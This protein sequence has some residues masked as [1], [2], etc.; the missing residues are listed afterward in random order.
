MLQDAIDAIRQEKY[1]RARDLLTRL[2]RQD[3]DNPT[4]WLWMSAAVQNRREKIYCLQNVIRND[5]QNQ[6]AK[7]GLVLLGASPIPKNAPIKPADHRKWNADL[8]LPPDLITES[9]RKNR[10]L[11]LFG[12]GLGILVFILILLLGFKL[13]ASKS[14]QRFVVAITKTEGVLPSYTPSPTFI[15]YVAQPTVTAGELEKQPTPLWAMLPATYTPTPIY[16]N[17]PHPI[18][19]A[20]RAGMLAYEQ[21]NWTSAANFFAQA[22]Q[23][24]TNA[25]DIA[26]YLAE[27]QRNS[28]NYSE[29]EKQY[30]RAIQLNPNFA[31]A[32]LGLAR[33]QF[34]QGKKDAGLANL[35]KAIQLDSNFAEAYIERANYFLSQNKLAEA[36]VDV[37]KLSGLLPLSPLP[38]IL[39]AKLALNKG[40]FD[41]AEEEAN[42]AFELDRTLI[43]TYLL[44]GNSALLNQDYG[45]AQDKLQVYLQYVKKDGLAWYLYGRAIAEMGSIKD[46]QQDWTVGMSN[47]QNAEKALSALQKAEINK[48][49]ES[50]LPLYR[51]SLY[52]ELKDGQQAVNDLLN[53]RAVVME[54]NKM[55][56]APDMWFAY[57]IALARAFF[58][59]GRY[60][61]AVSQLNLAETLAKE[62]QQ[63]A[64]VYYWRGFVYDKDGKQSLANRDWLALAGLPAE[65]I[66]EK[67]RPTIEERLLQL[68]PTPRSTIETGTPTPRP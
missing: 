36:E 45:L 14:P 34:K 68:T 62:G 8:R 19:E 67:F 20:Y 46:L 7:Q 51:S 25:A 50:D 57:Q 55:G 49:N 65:V 43:E 23:V 9:N 60:S 66:P 17:T 56:Q 30:Q 3:Q 64:L 22:L 24:E 31:P 26:Y 15:G 37:A 1:D 39:K 12:G 44:Y 42:Q 2:I 16:I 41:V 32:Y 48:S 33:I 18:S 21:S 52:L 29:A 6:V 11:W 59:S 35:N 38:H 28:G 61:D 5:P 54:L 47:P 53:G 13:A 63:K 58:Y 27:S 10:S 40:D 4:Y